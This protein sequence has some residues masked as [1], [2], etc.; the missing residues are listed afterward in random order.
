MTLLA[1]QPPPSLRPTDDPAPVE[2]TLVA[3]IAADFEPETFLWIHFR[4]ADGGTRIRYAW[5]TGGEPLGDH[6]DSLATAAGL[7]AADWLHIADRHQQTTTRGRI[8]IWAYPL[9]P[10]LGDVTSGVR[11]PEARRED[12]RRLLNKASEIT[13]QQPRTL[14]PR[15]L[16]FGPVLTARPN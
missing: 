13:R 16:G 2:K 1:T 4:R 8:E 15:W 7:D 5:T 9:R 12:L 3:S 14:T 6:I 11:G 10:V